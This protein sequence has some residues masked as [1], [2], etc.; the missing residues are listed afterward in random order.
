MVE[1]YDAVNLDILTAFTSQKQQ[2]QFL[3]LS[4]EGKREDS[5]GI[6]L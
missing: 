3:E 1:Q 6:L 5:C 2:Q 4:D